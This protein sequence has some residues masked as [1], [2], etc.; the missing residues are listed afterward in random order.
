V[1]LVAAA[2]PANLPRYY[3][4][5]ARVGLRA[6]Q[7]ATIELHPQAR[8]PERRLVPASGCPGLEDCR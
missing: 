8:L 2:R 5:G 3:W 6:L 7:A 4:Q 1:R